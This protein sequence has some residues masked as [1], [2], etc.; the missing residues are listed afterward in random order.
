MILVLE[1]G[2]REYITHR[3]QYIP[4]IEVVYTPSWA[5]IH[6]LPPFTIT[7]IILVVVSNIFIFIPNLGVA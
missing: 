7:R 2:G 5:I 6:C 4:G 3:R 1:K